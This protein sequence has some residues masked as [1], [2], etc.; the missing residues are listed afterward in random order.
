MKIL[1]TLYF[2]FFLAKCVCTQADLNFILKGLKARDLIVYSNNENDLSEEET[3]KRL[4][5]I[6]GENLVAA[7]KKED[8]E[9][10]GEPIEP[11]KK[12]KKKK[13]RKCKEC[14]CRVCGI[15][16]GMPLQC[17]ECEYLIHI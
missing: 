4:L 11:C 8:N 3:E 15:D 17:D 13:G 16:E 7:I 10:Q 2:L 6:C 12:C 1:P 14:N 9:D 5:E